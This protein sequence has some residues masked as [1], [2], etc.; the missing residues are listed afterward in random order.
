MSDFAF[1]QLILA[2]SMTVADAAQK[3]GC[4]PRTVTMW[5]TKWPV[6][7]KIN[8]AAYRISEPLLDLCI[9]DDPDEC[10][11][12]AEFLA[13]KPDWPKRATSD[14]KGGHSCFSR[15]LGALPRTLTIGLLCRI[16]DGIGNRYLSQNVSAAPP[17]SIATHP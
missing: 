17:L 6:G 15:P 12:A 4:H 5:L 10:A 2:R 11:A 1:R 9:S 8:G 14:L 16:A 7:V 13:G 3:Y